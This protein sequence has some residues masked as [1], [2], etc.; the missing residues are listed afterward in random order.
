DLNNREA[1]TVASSTR[2]KIPTNLVVLKYKNAYPIVANTITVL[3]I[4][5]L[6][7]SNKLTTMRLIY[8]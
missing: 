3:A 7:Q 8:R 1:K 4:L 6:C 5:S 2:M